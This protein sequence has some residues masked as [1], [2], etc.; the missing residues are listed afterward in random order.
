MTAMTPETPARSTVPCC[1][2]FR[3]TRRTLLKGAAAIV[4]FAAFQHA[5]GGV[6]RDVAMAAQGETGGNVLV[7]LSL[8]GGADGLSMVVPYG[9]PGYYAAR[10]Q[11]A[12]PEG[13][14]LATDGMFG[15]HPCFAPL[16]PMW[17]TGTFGAAHAVGL[18]QPNRSHFAAMEEMEDADL[19]SPERRGWLNRLVGTNAGSSPLHA[20]ALGRATV[21]TALYGQ[22]PVLS[23]DSVHAMRL[24]GPTDPERASWKRRSL[25]HMWAADDDALG[26]SARTTLSASQTM[27]PLATDPGT[28]A[29]DAVYPAGDLGRCLADTARLIRHG[30]GVETVAID[31]GDWDMHV[32][33]GKAD[34]G[35]MADNID[36]FARA[37]AA[38]FQ[39]LGPLSERVTLVTL[40]EFGRRTEENGAHGFDHGYGN[41]MLLFG[42]GVAGGRVHTQ[43][44][45][46]TEGSL[47]SGDLAVTRDYRSVLSEVLRRQF[48]DRS[49]AE[50]FPGLRPEQVGVM[51]T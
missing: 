33:L 47:V 45:G 10:P 19:G 34:R 9:D 51:Q 41:A 36:V 18:P 11:T 25:Q 3:T 31:Y 8:R 48:P 39:D 5:G 46:L 29:P 27:L 23:A 1:A 14:L 30:V 44:P 26:R 17:N 38:F 40:S 32:A 12:I 50:V 15:L 21:P 13:S 43:W 24:V 37:V 20:V 42:A 4:G 28:A 6:F 49:I 22:A 35:P 2:E 7:V 16:L